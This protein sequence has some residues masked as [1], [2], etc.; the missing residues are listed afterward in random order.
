[1]TRIMTGTEDYHGWAVEIVPLKEIGERN[2][3]DAILL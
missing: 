2:E 3:W 1:M